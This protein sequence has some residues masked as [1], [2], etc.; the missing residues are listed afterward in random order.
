LNLTAYVPPWAYPV[1]TIYSS[2]FGEH[3][4]KTEDR[5]N[6]DTS[7]PTTDFIKL[8]IIIS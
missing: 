6:T 5:T 4:E 8:I 1:M 3:E 2:S 7:N